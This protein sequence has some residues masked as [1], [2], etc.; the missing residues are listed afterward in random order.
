MRLR[1][2]VAWVSERSGLSELAAVQVKTTVLFLK[3][4]NC[5]QY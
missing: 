5:E 2:R 1:Q 3:G 4:L